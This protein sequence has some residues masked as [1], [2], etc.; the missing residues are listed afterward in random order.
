MCVL[1]EC[2]NSNNACVPIKTLLEQTKNAICCLIREMDSENIKLKGCQDRDT[3]ICTMKSNLFFD[4]RNE[5]KFK[6]KNES[7]I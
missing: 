6:S 2:Y 5:K 4:D 3:K 7:G 1:K